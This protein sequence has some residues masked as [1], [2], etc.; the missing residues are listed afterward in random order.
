MIHVVT[1]DNR[2]RYEA[3][4][5]AMHRQRKEIFVDAY[6]WKLAVRDGGEYDE[7]D[8]ERAIYFLALG[9]DGLPLCS[10]RLRPADD[11]SIIEDHFPF[12]LAPDEARLTTGRT[13]EFARAVA[14]GPYRGHRGA[15]AK[16]EL[17]LAM[18]EHAL[19]EGCGRI[20]GFMDVSGMPHLDST[21]W[22]Y[23][24][25]GLPAPYAEGTAIAFEVEV[26]NA[27]VA[28][29]REVWA[30]GDEV[31]IADAPGVSRPAA[32]RLPHAAGAAG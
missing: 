22:R 21:G 8:D 6:G 16:A 19:F 10:T 31:V 24:Y 12:L 30:F 2:H 23:R 25:L 3:A 11:G 9:D 32:S 4:L 17:R 28:H 7:F 1:A 13:W 29:K 26:S 20:V 27:A 14:V 5:A 18:L 15:R